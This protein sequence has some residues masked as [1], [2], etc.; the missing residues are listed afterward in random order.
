MPVWSLG[1]HARTRRG[2][3][4]VS[5]SGGT[6]DGEGDADSSM[7][8]FTP[9]WRN[10]HDVLRSADAGGATGSLVAI[11]GAGE[12]E[13]SAGRYGRR[14]RRRTRRRRS[15]PANVDMSDQEAVRLATHILTGS[16]GPLVAVSPTLGRHRTARL[17]P[18]VP[19]PPV[20]RSS[21]PLLLSARGP[22][23]SPS[24]TTLSPAALRPRPHRPSTGPRRPPRPHPAQPPLVDGTGPGWT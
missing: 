6:R 4:E 3:A 15:R 8:R 10:D 18:S 12:K 5:T 20:S 2:S 23:A 24:W 9:S 16:F 19:T 13:G 7:I 21:S 11:V 14:W 1:E 22:P 17:P